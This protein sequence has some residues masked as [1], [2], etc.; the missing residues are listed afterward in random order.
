M[1]INERIV[2]QW[3]A[4]DTLLYHV[5]NQIDKCE[6]PCGFFAWPVI[7][8]VLFCIAAVMAMYICFLAGSFYGNHAD[9]MLF[10]NKLNSVV[11][12]IYQEVLIIHSVFHQLVRQFLTQPAA[13]GFVIV[14]GL[15]IF[16]AWITS[17]AILNK[18]LQMQAGRKYI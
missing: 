2:P 13:I 14:I 11:F 16:V 4:P 3:K 10:V 18:M 12:T 9:I 15:A 17:I 7:H 5:M 6:C 1:N 8:R